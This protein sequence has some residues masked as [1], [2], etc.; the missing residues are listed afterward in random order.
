MITMTWIEIALRN[1]VICAALEV[2]WWPPDN[3]VH[4]ISTCAPRMRAM[5]ILPLD[6]GKVLLSS[7]MVKYPEVTR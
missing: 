5:G 2:S 6:D 1:L 7:L 4:P 3:G